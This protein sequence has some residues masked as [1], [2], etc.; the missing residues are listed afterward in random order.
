MNLAPRTPAD[1]IDLGPGIE[2]LAVIETTGDWMDIAVR[3]DADAAIG[4]RDLFLDQAALPAAV[5]VY[6]AVH[7]VAVT[8]QA[9]MARVG[10]VSFPKQYQ[11]FEA[12][13][14]HDGPDGESDTDDDLDLGIV[15]VAWTLEEYAATFG[16]D[17]LRYVGEIDEQAPS[18]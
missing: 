7:R 17:D 11:Q 1:A 16:D 2:V 9:G 15:D 13:A 18:R 12:R 8:P 4:E 3:V 10:G 6:D 5:V 14:F